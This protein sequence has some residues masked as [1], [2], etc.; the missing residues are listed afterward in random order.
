MDTSTN[1][2]RT[3]KKILAVIFLM[4][5]LAWLSVPLYRIFCQVTGYGGTPQVISEQDLPKVSHQTIRVRFDASTANHL[6]WEFTPKEREI[7][8]R[9]GETNLAFYEA[10]N[11]TDKPITGSAT[12]NVTPYTTGTYF[13][14]IDCFCFQEQT[15]EPQER[16]LMPVSF[17]VDPEIMD[18]PEANYTTRITLSYTFFPKKDKKADESL[19]QLQ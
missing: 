12:F 10:Y 4:G 5:A 18:D 8:V 2:I 6:P 9:L 14:K 11:P 15:L 7:T 17:F 1:N 19:T 3:L 13:V 16:V